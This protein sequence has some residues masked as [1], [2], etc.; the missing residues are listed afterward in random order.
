MITARAEYMTV[1]IKRHPFNAASAE[2]AVSG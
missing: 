2:M 1:G